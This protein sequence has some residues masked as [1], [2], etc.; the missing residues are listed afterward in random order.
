MTGEAIALY[1]EFLRIFPESV[2][3]TAVRSFITQLK[4]EQE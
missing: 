4:K 3:A 1:Q 2:E